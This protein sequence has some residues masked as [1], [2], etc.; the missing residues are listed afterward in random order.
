MAEDN[1]HCDI[2]RSTSSKKVVTRCRQK[3]FVQN[4]WRGCC[5]IPKY[6]RTY[7]KWLVKIRSCKFSLQDEPKSR[8]PSNVNDEDL[9]CMIQ[10]NLTL[11]SMY[12]NFK[13]G[14]YQTSALD[15]IKRFGFV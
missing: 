10:T 11:T 9:R 5:N 4:V 15:H 12:V 14:I 3:K 6:V 13:H 1:T 7:Q 8:K 2:E